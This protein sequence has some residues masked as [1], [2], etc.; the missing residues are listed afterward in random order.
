M[1]KTGVSPRNRVRLSNRATSG[2]TTRPI[3]YMANIVSPGTH[4]GRPS[5]RKAPIK[6]MYTGSR[7]EQLISG[8]TRIVASRSRGLSMTRADI[9]PGTAQATDDSIGMNDLPDRPQ[10]A[11]SLSIRNAAR[12]M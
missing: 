6:R 2:A 12:A 5:V 10:R 3:A 1:T 7:A 11:I 8:A 9:T 4:H